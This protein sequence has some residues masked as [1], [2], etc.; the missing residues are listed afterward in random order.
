VRQISFTFTIS[1]LVPGVA[2]AQVGDSWP[3]R[4]EI[5]RTR[6]GVPHLL[7]RDIGALGYAM[8]WVQ[9]EDYG[10]RLSHAL[11][12]ARG[13]LGRYFGRDSLANDFAARQSH[14]RAAA[15]W[16]KLEPETRE[17]FEGFA[18][19]IN[20]YAI[21]HPSEFP[22]WMPHDATG[23]DVAA[24]W[25]EP[26]IPPAAASFSRRR[27]A[28][29][30]SQADSARVRGEGSNAWAFGPGRTTSGRAILLRN[31]HLD[32]DAGYYEMQVTVPGIVNFYGDFRIGAPVMLVGGFNEHL[33]WATTNN[34]PE[35][36]A[37]YALDVD[38]DRPDHY[39]FD[40]ASVPMERV[41]VRA[42]YRNGPGLSTETRELWR[43]P[44]GPVIERAD[45]KVYIVRWPAEGEFRKGEQ[46]FRM[47]RASNL[48]EW[49][50]AMRL[51]A[52]STSNFTYA[53]A[54]GN[55]FYVW[56]AATPR[57][58]H[59]SGGDSV[60]IP[61]RGMAD[62][63]TEAVP[64]DDLP[65]LL[66][67]AGGYL[68]NAND[69]FH[70]TNLLAVLD[71][72]RYPAHLSRPA[73]GFRS[74]LSL[75]L[76]TAQPK[77]SLEEV[78]RLKHDTRML[79]AVRLKDDLVAAVRGAAPDT[80]T[81]RAVPVLERWDNTVSPEAR[82]AVLFETWLARYLDD[83]ATRGRPFAARWRAAFTTPWRPAAPTTT[84]DGLADPARA[85]RDLAAAAEETI[86]R[87]GALDVAWG[88]VHRVRRG[89]VDVPVGGCN[90]LYGCFRVLWYNQ[91]PDG[92]RVVR[93][94]DGWVL[95]VELG[96]APR[97]YSVLAYGQ[98]N[99]AESPH[100]ADQAAM[101]ARGE[102][103]RV[104]FTEA[105]VARETVRRYRPGAR[106]DVR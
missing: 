86:R 63:W 75:L 10:T 37:I 70:F 88:D 102:M 66:N 46:F 89:S 49:K 11:V 24:L 28:E 5:R 45:G 68:Q 91:G 100:Y 77:M 85:A 84:P 18:E 15:T 101:F 65:Q 72:T 6:F 60:A 13:H 20:A 98:S 4:V 53:D 41:A 64:F 42:E 76:A 35:L 30:R 29:R 62:V 87:F 47:M 26:A 39:R 95:A 83:P 67:P 61:A 58:P 44:I 3:D 106:L 33:A 22:A 48:G 97:A 27:A 12:R 19:G 38:P 34:D 74:Q 79:A 55:I 80:L 71:S 23:Q 7:A 92:K 9:L 56:N 94:G 1:L 105:E 69:P 78:V 54:R 21:Q 57:L 50:A 8:A 82:G 104:A 73:L 32:W 52:H 99:R 31:P 90:G 59:P 103:K 43:T 51:R 36:A 16:G 17:L 96:E 40:G 81:A 14:A 2:A 93:G 25:M